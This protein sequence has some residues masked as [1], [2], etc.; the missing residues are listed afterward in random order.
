ML[1]KIH[2]FLKKQSKNP[3]NKFQCELGEL[4]EEKLL[5]VGNT[6]GLFQSRYSFNEWLRFFSFPKKKLKIIEAKIKTTETADAV[7]YLDYFVDRYK[8]LERRPRYIV[9]DFCVYTYSSVS[10]IDLFKRFLSPNYIVP[11]D[12]KSLREHLECIWL[13]YRYFYPTM[14]FIPVDVCLR[15]EF[16]MHKVIFQ[17]LSLIEVKALEDLLKELEEE[18]R[19]EK[20]R[21][22]KRKIKDSRKQ[23]VL[24]AYYRI[25]KEDNMRPHRIA[26][27]IKEYMERRNQTAPS[28]STIKRYLEEEDLN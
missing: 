16:V 7:K 1:T 3:E 27:N 5:H 19:L 8:P 12:V 11:G 17:V 14:D 24:E 13:Y 4:W 18:K 6:F 2:Q 9:N 20:S 10:L 28:I 21:K 25:D 15:L 23:P 26:I 22:A